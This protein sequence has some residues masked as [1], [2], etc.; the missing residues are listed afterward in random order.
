MSKKE[1]KNTV[2][3]HTEAK[4][5][6]YIYYLERYLPVLFKASFVEKINIY[7]MF[8]GQAFYNDG[9]ES[10][11]VRAFNTIKEVQNNNLDS[12]TKIT[13]TLNDWLFRKIRG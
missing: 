7:D 1:T 5:K 6:F 4:L 12:N 9:K 8:C 3:P 13:L 2:K 11:A 10:G